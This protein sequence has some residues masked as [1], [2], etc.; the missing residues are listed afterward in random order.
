MHALAVPPASRSSTKSLM[1]RWSSEC[2]SRVILPAVELASASARGL[3][4]ALHRV[5][6]DTLSPITMQERA[7]QHMVVNVYVGDSLPANLLAVEMLADYDHDIPKSLHCFMRCEIHQASLITTR[8][9]R[10]YDLVDCL[11]CLAKLLKD[12]KLRGRFSEVLGAIVRQEIVENYICAPPN[13]DNRRHHQLLWSLCFSPVLTW[14]EVA[15]DN[16][17]LPRQRQVKKSILAGA[18]TWRQIFNGPLHQQATHYCEGCCASAEEASRHVMVTRAL[19]TIIC[20]GQNASEK[21]LFLGKAKACCLYTTFSKDLTPIASQPR[22]CA[23]LPTKPCRL[24]RMSCWRFWSWAQNHHLP[25]GSAYQQ[26]CEG[27]Y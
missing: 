13:R 24:Q 20:T 9:V 16:D 2:A 5:E 7:Q 19:Q 22:T 15:R 11:Y 8:P 18:P 25:S 1:W 23:R 14:F 3:V 4:E 21:S 17:I 26:G 12:K 27:H 10:R 6:P